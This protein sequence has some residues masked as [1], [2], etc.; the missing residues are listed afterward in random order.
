MVWFE[1]KA[2]GGGDADAGAEEDFEVGEVFSFSRVEMTAITHGKSAFVG[3]LFDGR[4]GGGVL[5][6]EVTRGEDD[7][8]GATSE[9]N[10]GDGVE[11]D[12]V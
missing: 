4:V 10:E 7:G 3:D 12:Q 1:A 8:V 9:S 11:G 5:R 2:D 6:R